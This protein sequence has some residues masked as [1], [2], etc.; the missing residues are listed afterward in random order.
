MLVQARQ[1]QAIRTDVQSALKSGNQSMSS[2]LEFGAG[3]PVARFHNSVIGIQ[4][5]KF[6]ML[7]LGMPLRLAKFIF[8]ICSSDEEKFRF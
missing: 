7:S 2:Y 6:F 3:R 1:A 5:P 8:K 4:P